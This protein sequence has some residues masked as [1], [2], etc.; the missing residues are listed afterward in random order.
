MNGLDAGR[1]V[2]DIRR[3]SAELGFRRV[4][5]ANIDLAGDEAH[6]LDWLRDG[7]AGEMAYMSRHGRKRTHPAELVPEP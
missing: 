3:W 1:L 2:G 5:V 7:F 4:G 6:F